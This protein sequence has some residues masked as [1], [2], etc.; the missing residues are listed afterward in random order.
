MESASFAVWSGN[1]DDITRGF[2]ET[3]R[4]SGGE[5]RLLLNERGAA[6]ADD[7]GLDARGHAETGVERSLGDARL[8]VVVEE[9]LEGDAGDLL[10]VE[11]DALDVDLAHAVL[12]PD[13][14]AHLDEVDA[15]EEFPERVALA[16]VARE[17]VEVDLGGGRS[18]ARRGDEVDVGDA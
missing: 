5:C 10:V 7:G 1:L 3:F 11:P 12:A 9:E 17:A 8:E 16:H 13:A 15:A 6:P 14:D 2:D 18:L 4:G